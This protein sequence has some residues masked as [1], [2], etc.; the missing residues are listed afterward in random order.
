MVQVTAKHN[1]SASKTD[2]LLRCAWWASPAVRLPP[3]TQ[4]ILKVP[5]APR[6]GR[7]YHKAKEI[8]LGGKRPAL[9]KI[10]KEYAVD[11]KKLTDYFRR[12]SEAVEKLLRK[13]GWWSEERWVEEKL[14]YD[15][16]A[17][18]GRILVSKGERDYSSKRVTELPGTVDLGVLSSKR[19]VLFDWKTGQ[20]QY[21]ID[22]NEQML[23]LSCA[24][25]KIR[26]RLPPIRM[27]VRIDDDFVEPYE[28]DTTASEL[29]NHRD[30]LKI[31]MRV[32]L[33]KNPPM[34]PGTYCN[35]CNALEICP[36]Q[37]GAYNAPLLLRDFIDGAL[38]RD[39]MGMIYGRL[40]AAE[41][42]TKRVRERIT[43]YVKQNGPLELD[44]GKY[45]KVVPGRTSNLSQASIKRALGPVQGNDVIQQLR[46]AGCIEETEFE[47]LKM[48]N[49][50]GA[51]K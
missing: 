15:P 51:K 48:V 2:L 33:S 14:A 47:A 39:Q 32:M 19:D 3:E 44:N 24:S 50:P 23:S 27:I 10:A 9:V 43:E 30:R 36:A 42:L 28:A 34:V 21:D 6:F 49:A 46:E 18:T 41:N 31:A 1:A 37:A 20:K 38:D 16:F 40:L 11:P 25:N 7:A 4:D 26:G 8:W 17:D 29:S 45:A 12:G 5:E 35:W 13:R 22:V